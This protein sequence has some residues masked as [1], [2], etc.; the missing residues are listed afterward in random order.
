[1]F[2]ANLSK[3][4]KLIFYLAGALILLS[5]VYKFALIPVGIKWSALNNRILDKEIELKRNTRYLQQENEVRALY[6][7][8]AGY[9]K[10]RGSDEEE[11][12]SLLNEV[13]KQASA[14]QIHIVNIRPAPV[15]SGPFFRKY[16]LELNCQAAMEDYIKFIYQIGKSGQLVRVETLKLVSQGKANPLLK[17]RMRIVNVLPPAN[18]EIR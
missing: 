6:Q 5:L 7:K 12:A 14:A 4:E 16:I 8:Y 13:E 17:A 10:R 11:I 2:L 18:E 1:V 15:K 3:R 9:V